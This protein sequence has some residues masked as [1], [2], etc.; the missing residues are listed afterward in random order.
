M[1][2]LIFPYAILHQGR[3]I[4]SFVFLSIHIQR[5]TL[6]DAHSAVLYKKKK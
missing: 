2:I 4:H 3:E 6:M 1:F 5:S